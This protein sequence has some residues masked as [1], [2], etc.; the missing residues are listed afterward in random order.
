MRG[1]KPLYLFAGPLFILAVL[2]AALSSPA[3]A[4]CYGSLSIS[5]AF[6][7]YDYLV[8]LCVHFGGGSSIP[9]D[10]VCN[11]SRIEG[12]DIIQVPIW[13]YNGHEGVGSLEF[14]IESNDSIISFAPENCFEIYSSSWHEYAGFNRMNVEIEACTPICGPALAGYVYIVPSAGS[15]LTWINI[16]PNADK[17]RMFASDA[18]GTGHYM[19]SPHHG[20]YVGNSYLYTCQQPICAEPN[21]PVTSL[22]AQ[23]GFA[24]AVKLTWTAGEGNWTVI[25][26]RTDRYPTGYDDGRRVVVM[27]CTP[28]QQLYFFDT[29]VPDL[30]IVYYKAFALTKD[31]SGNILNNSFVECSATDTAFVRNEI[32]TESSSWGALKSLGL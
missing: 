5:P 18:S 19:F 30:A 13:F 21:M 2:S 8:R 9:E 28:G 23:A 1:R 32:A 12:E 27:P 14:A 7:E 31:A 17:G 25:M 3:F 24:R 16:V 6:F 10:I 29:A 15:E 11:R 20:G 26:A 22:V 4:Q